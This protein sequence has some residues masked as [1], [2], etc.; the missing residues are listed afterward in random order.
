MEKLTGGVSIVPNVT[1]SSDRSALDEERRR[2]ARALHDS[3]TQELGVVLWQLRLARSSDVSV[4][5]KIELDQT[6]LMAEAAMLRVRA[7]MQVLRMRE[8]SAATV[9]FR[10]R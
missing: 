6:V 7:L 10:S 9:V 1:K 5:D 3:V 2:I 8:S 4:K